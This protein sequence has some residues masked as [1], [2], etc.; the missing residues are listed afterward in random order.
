MAENTA[1]SFKLFD[2]L[3]YGICIV[4]RDYR[5]RFWNRVMEDWTG[6]KREETVGGNFLKIY[7]QVN[8]PS[9]LKRLEMVFSSGAPVIFSSQLH[10]HIIPCPLNDGSLRILHT[11]VSLIR[12]ESQ[13]H[14]L[15]LITVEDMTVYVRQ[16]K[17]ISE[18][19]EEAI[20]EMDER[21]KMELE[22]LKIRQME[23]IGLLA[24]GIAHDFNNILTTVIGN[25][26][27]ALN[28]IPPGDRNRKSL[29]SAL[30]SAEKAAVL[31]H[32][33]T[34]FSNGGFMDP[35]ILDMNPIIK[36]AVQAFGNSPDIEFSL[37]LADTPLP[38]YGD[39]G[40][41]KQVLGNLFLNAS[42]AMQGKGVIRIKSE[43]APAV[44]EVKYPMLKG[45]YVKVTVSDIG[46]GIS[47]ENLPRIFD[48][49]FSTKDNVT[50]K[51][52]G[53]GL[54]LCYSI[55]KRHQ[56]YIFVDSLPGEGTGVE[57]FIPVT[58]KEKNENKETDPF[59]Y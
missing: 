18:L 16:L 49:Y 57:L 24:S 58:D 59:S 20:R 46:R 7:P 55:I 56:G 30:A 14:N 44:S 19:R 50:Q 53:M 29:E 13:S 45:V 54:T 47:P 40:Q 9:Y 6:K 38:V 4:D 42:E 5:I 3:L 35:V 32:R 39:E 17:K 34:T 27:L 31:A 8:R 15:A 23:A 28:F 12:Q 21:K 1:D 41:L 33:F 51:G 43:M 52:L 2:H 10:P 25:I 22:L 11:T 36:E 37:S 26:S 48:P